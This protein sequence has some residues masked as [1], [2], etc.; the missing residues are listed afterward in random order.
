MSELREMLLVA[1][2]DGEM[3]RRA[4]A[5]QRGWS[6]YPA[7]QPNEEEHAV[8]TSLLAEHDIQTENAMTRRI[9]EWLTAGSSAAVEAGDDATGASLRRLADGARIFAAPSTTD[10]R[11]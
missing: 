2:A 4:R 6:C 5:G 7:T 11:P 8:A 10:P 1:L 9:V 3:L